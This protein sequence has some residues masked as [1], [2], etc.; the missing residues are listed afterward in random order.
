MSS[1]E[2]DKQI[3]T[4]LNRDIVNRHSYFQLKYF[5][6]GKEQTLQSKMWCCIREL[7]ARQQSIASMRM[8]LEDLED[9]VTLSNIEIE[10][11]MH[12][13]LDANP[14]NT[15][16]RAIHVRKR[17]RHKKSLEES[18]LDIRKKL[19]D[20]LEEADF[21]VRTFEALSKREE[22]KPYDDFQSQ[23]AYWNEK[24]SQEVYLRA[25]LQ[26]PLDLELVKTILCTQDDMP[27]RKEL[28][29]M[30]ESKKQQ[31]IA[32]SKVKTVEPSQIEHAQGEI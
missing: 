28:L 6:V 22:L 20:A 8:K 27:I 23:M 9:D 15:Q 2:L 5:V 25:L 1:Q 24:L 13:E 19:K 26:K 30:L 4:I 29:D 7:Q 14:L 17:E 18:I 10:R 31:L 12:A 21:F 11:L 32:A 16:E 3:S